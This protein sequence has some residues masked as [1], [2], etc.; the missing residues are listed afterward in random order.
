LFLV[1]TIERPQAFAAQTVDFRQIKADA[2]FVDR[3]NHAA[4]LDL[5]R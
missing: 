2:G 5:D 4:S 3:R 1:G